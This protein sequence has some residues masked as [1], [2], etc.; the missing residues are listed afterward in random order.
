MPLVQL[1]RYKYPLS[2]EMESMI[3]LEAKKNNESLEFIDSEN[4]EIP[5][6]SKTDQDENDS[7]LEAPHDLESKNISSPKSANPE[8]QVCDRCS[9]V[10]VVKPHLEEYEKQECH[11]HFGVLR[12]TTVEGSKVRAY[13][14]CESLHGTSGCSIGPHVFKEDTFKKLNERVGFHILTI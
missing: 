8:E 9:K 4:S 7:D 10:F 5:I 6:E 3:I 2:P 11:Y 14:C 13:T 12:S 1:V